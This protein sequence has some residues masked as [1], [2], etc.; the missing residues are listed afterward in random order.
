MRGRAAIRRWDEATVFH[1][2]KRELIML[3][4]V[5]SLLAATVLAGSILVAAPALA[6]DEETG[7]GHGF[8]VTGSVA[9]VTDYR[10][11]GVSLSGGNFAIQGG[12]TLNHDSG[13]YLGTWSSSLENTPLYGEVE[14]DFFAG[15]GG[16]VSDAYGVRY[17]VW[18]GHTGVA[19]RSW[20]VVDTDQIVRFSWV[21]DDAL[22]LPVLDE[23]VAAVKA[24]GG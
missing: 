8:S 24:L 12:I 3:T 15:W 1:P 19:K 23:I 10:F 11:R 4:S 22:E 16:E 2:N 18:K 6:Q 20:F 13:F 17:D 7:G 9:A 5:R 21:T 14:T